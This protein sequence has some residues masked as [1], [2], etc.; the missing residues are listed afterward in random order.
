MMKRMLA[1]VLLACPLAGS[2]GGAAADPV[3]HRTEFDISFGLLQVGRATFDIRIDGDGYLL[4][5]NGRTAGI[6]ELFAEGRGSVESEGHIDGAR[7]TPVRHAVEYVEKQKKSTM[8]MLF[9][10]GRVGKIT[11]EPDKRKKKKGRKWVPITEEQLASVID[12]ASGIVVPVIPADAR[13]PHAVCNR[14][15]PIYDGD[16]RYDIAL[17]YKDTRPVETKGYRGQA[18]VC[19][20]R[21]VPVAGHRRGQKN[22]EYM[23][24]NDGMEIW[25]APIAGT[26]A[27]TPIRI[28][29]PTWVGRV[30]AVARYFGPRKD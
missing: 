26:A 15:L 7:V 1:A 3:L 5:G 17:S 24:G 23:S 25:L 16:T 19:T 2:P 21:Y 27:F 11:L 18:F 28:E 30:S 22:I 20:L 10:E 14:V 13:D 8:E 4:D 12:P 29:V 9:E 6:V